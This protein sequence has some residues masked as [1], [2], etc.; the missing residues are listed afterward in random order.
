MKLQGSYRLSGLKFVV[1]ILI[2]I[3]LVTTVQAQENEFKQLP[4]K[5]RAIQNLVMGIQS[6]NAGLKRSCIYF[7]GKYEVSEVVNELIE[8]LG[9]E[10]DSSTKKVIALVLYKI[11]D[12]KGIN[13]IKKLAQTDS[14]SKVRNLCSAITIAYNKNITFE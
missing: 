10:K 13:A 6:D 1:Y 4:N 8:L 9:K 3:F 2:T 5:E 7:A 14:D 12:Q 11:G